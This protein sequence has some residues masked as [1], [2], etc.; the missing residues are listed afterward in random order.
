MIRHLE[1][2]SKIS[3]FKFAEYLD[4]LAAKRR[5]ACLSLFRQNTTDGV[6]RLNESLKIRAVF[7]IAEHQSRD[8]NSRKMYQNSRATAANRA[9]AAATC[10][11]MR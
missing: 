8:M 5:L 3:R 9:R 6:R 2:F 11:P 10:W 7:G 4:R 1:N